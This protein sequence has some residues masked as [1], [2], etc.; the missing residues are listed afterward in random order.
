[1]SDDRY[2]VGDLT[3]YFAWC[4]HEGCPFVTDNYVSAWIL[5]D[6]RV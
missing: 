4:T 1:M 2:E 6:S 3:S 5:M